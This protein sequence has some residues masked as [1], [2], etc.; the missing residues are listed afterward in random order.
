MKA[1][2]MISSRFEGAQAALCVHAP[3][4]AVPKTDTDGSVR[5][6]LTGRAAG[7]GGRCWFGVLR[8]AQGG[9]RRAHVLRV[10]GGDV[11]LSKIMGL[12]V[13]PGTRRVPL[14]QL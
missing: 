7:K 5:G 12:R 8:D 10:V 1:C 4:P 6:L 3:S 11:A 2:E 13:N 14:A 9:P